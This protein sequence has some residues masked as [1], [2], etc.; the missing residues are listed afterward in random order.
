MAVSD[1]CVNVKAGVGG[2]VRPYREI[3]AFDQSSTKPS[4]SLRE[5]DKK[6]F[7]GRAP[8]RT[9]TVPESVTSR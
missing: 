9:R 1:D 7:V 4:S 3:R 5:K 2:G 8:L 6:P